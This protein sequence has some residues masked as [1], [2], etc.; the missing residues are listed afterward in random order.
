M[1]TQYAK[2]ILAAAH[3]LLHGTTL[4]EREWVLGHLI[5]KPT[6]KTLRS[7]LGIEILKV[8]KDQECA[9]ARWI[10]VELE[11]KKFTPSKNELHN[12]LGHLKRM[13]LL[14][15]PRRGLFCEVKGEE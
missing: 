10:M 2:A 7:P 14:M 5:I 4:A 8:L 15:S 6:T 9:N 3:S 1:T 13:G 12:C 11:K